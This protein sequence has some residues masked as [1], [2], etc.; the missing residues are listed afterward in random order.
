MKFKKA[1]PLI[2]ALCMAG[3][4]FATACSK[5]DEGDKGGDTNQNQTDNNQ[6]DDNQNDDNQNDD[7]GGGQGD[8]HD[9]DYSGQP[10]VNDGASGH[11]QVCKVDGCTEQK[12][13]AHT[14]AQHKTT[15]DYC[16]F[17]N[18]K[19]TT[20][21]GWDGTDSGF[22]EDNVSQIY[23]V[24]DSTVCDYESSIGQG[25]LDEIFLPRYGYG[26]QLHEYL[27]FDKANVVNLAM[28]GRSAVSLMGEESYQ[29]LVN[30]IGKGDYLI[31]GFGHND[32]KL[33]PN[34]FGDPNGSTSEAVTDRGDS[35]KY[36][37]NENYIKLAKHRGATPILCTPIVRYDAKGQYTGNYI[38]DTQYG[39]YPEALK[40]LGEE[41]ETTVVDLTTLTKNLWTEAGADAKYFHSHSSYVGAIKTAGTYDGTEELKGID[42]T[43]IN[44]YGAKAVAYEIANALK[45]TTL[46]T[47]V[48]D[49][50]TK[51]TKAAE[52]VGA[53]KQD[54]VKLPYSS[55]DPAKNQNRIVNGD[56]YKAAMGVSV[57]DS[58]A[59]DFTMSY[60]GDKYTI[61]CNNKGKIQS[62]SDGFGAI[63]MQLDVST[64]FTI[65]V[66]AKVTDF[67]STVSVKQGGFGIMLRDDIY[68]DVQDAALASN[69]VTAGVLTNEGAT[70]NDTAAFSRV[71][72]KLDK[73]VALNGEAASGSE[74]DI[75]MTKTGT[76]VEVTVG[77]V[78]KTFE[79]VKLNEVDE[80]NMYL[81]LFTNRDITVEFTNVVYTPAQA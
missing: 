57:G 75:T 18:P 64:D 22:T 47:I 81:C 3:S 31:I 25:H 21:A 36:I 6:N 50:I 1:L 74:Y 53:I 63:F 44:K 13:A 70:N 9:H 39:N 29:T 42:G 5:K 27:N 77:T 55:F 33:E 56:W 34:K 20:F 35:W 24:G 61:D 10:Y 7:Q 12:P 78:S 2:L 38:H 37:L 51:P 26:T 59:S 58:P 11:H 79:N 73:G 72:T 45:E 48:R 60:A 32:E 54:Y 52:Y 67:N 66:H 15:C 71:D 80:F 4:V 8:T 46:S 14:Y 16:N 62:G 65:S 69:Y 41:T 30:S 40:Q 68:L 19:A 23:V 28:S 17:H 43:H 49:G 76:T